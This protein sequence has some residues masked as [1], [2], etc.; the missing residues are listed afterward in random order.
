MTLFDSDIRCAVADD[1]Q[2][3]PCYSLALQSRDLGV[4]YSAAQCIRSISRGVPVLRTSLVDT[5]LGLCV[6]EK[7][8]QDGE[9]RRVMTAYLAVICNLMNDFS[10]LKQVR[11]S[12]VGVYIIVNSRSLFLY[13]RQCST[14]ALLLV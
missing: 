4:R 6:F 7:V 9:D 10:P 8:K 2:L 13:N 11:M 3:L 1:F 12:F 5:G 14:K